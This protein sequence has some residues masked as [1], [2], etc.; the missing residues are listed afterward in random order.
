MS[1]P[2][3]IRLRAAWEV[4]PIARWHAGRMQAVDAAPQNRRIH[5]PHDWRKLLG[6]DFVGIA[7]YSRHFNMPDR[8]ANHERL[9]LC[10]REAYESGQISLNGNCLGSVDGRGAGAEFDITALLEPRNRLVI[11]VQSRDS[12]RPCGL[13]GEVWLE[14]RSTR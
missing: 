11:D 12:S 3:V 5:V 6:P 13:T 14:V 7:R 1:D 10:C 4:E 8:L 2:H 9:W